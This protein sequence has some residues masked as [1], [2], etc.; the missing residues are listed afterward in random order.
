MLS[1]HFTDSGL[2]LSRLNLRQT[3]GRRT[4][5]MSVEASFTGKK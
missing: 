1:L 5:N 3:T 4:G 2:Y